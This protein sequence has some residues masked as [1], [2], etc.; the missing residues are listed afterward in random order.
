MTGTRRDGASFDFASNNCHSGNQ[1][2]TRGI[3]DGKSQTAQDEPMRDWLLPIAPIA[4]LLY[5]AIYPQELY[6]LFV[7]AGRYIH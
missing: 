6:A 1:F 2:Y 3:D 5:F 7:W 4:T